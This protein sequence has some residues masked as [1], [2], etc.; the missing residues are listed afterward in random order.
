MCAG[1]PVDS[2]QMTATPK[3]DVNADT[4]AYFG[5]P[6]YSYA[7]KDGI[8][9][10][11]LTPFKVRQMASTLDEYTWSDEDELISGEIDRYREADFNTTLII[12]ER[13]Q[14]RVEEFMDQID[15]R[16]K[17]LVFCATQEHAARVRDITAAAFMEQLFGD[18]GT[19]IGS[20][21]ELRAVWSDPERRMRFI[22]RL[23]ELGYDADRIEDMRRLIDAPNSDI[24]DVLAYVRF[25]LAPLARTDRAG[26]A[27]SS[28]L[29]GYEAEMRQFLNYV[30]QAY[31]THGVEE[32]SLPKIGDFLR[33]RYGGVS[34]AKA[35][36][37]ATSEIRRAFIDI[38]G[39]LFR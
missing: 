38:Q 6:V 17:T 13:E 14:S 26:A 32:L 34:D 8:G 3:R 4:Y 36:L 20:E 30:L 12:H 9:D 21:D 28:G 31:E 24:F 27:R 5:D 25:N 35:R 23:G 29:G 16:Q 18:L 33:I 10:G 37:G 7:L 15:Q 11:F 39:H 19:M 1:H 22:R 2:L